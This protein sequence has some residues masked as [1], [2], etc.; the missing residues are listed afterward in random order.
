MG[1]EQ[2]DAQKI[3]Y[4]HCKKCHGELG[5]PTTRGKALDAPDFTDR[6]WQASRLDAELIEAITNGKDKM[7][8]WKD[9][10]TPE[11]IKAAARWVRV[12][13]PRKK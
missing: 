9:V 11:E 13:G 4:A 6:I 5:K 3:Y 1:N 8:S 7:P 12:L 10:L 2:I